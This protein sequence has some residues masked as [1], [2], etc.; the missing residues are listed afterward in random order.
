M[1]AAIAKVLAAIWNSLD[2]EKRAGLISGIAILVVC[3]ICLLLLPFYLMSHPIEAMGLAESDADYAIIQQFRETNTWYMP[4]S[5]AADTSIV[6]DS[7]I[8]ISGDLRDNQIPL[9]LQGDK[10]WGHHPY[11]DHGTL[12]TS[13]CGP[14]SMA[15]VVV[16]LTGNTDVN[17][18]VTADW[19]A[20]HGYRASA[21]TSWGFF[22][23]CACAYGVH[24]SQVSYNAKS[25]TETLRSGKV[26]I[27]SMK[28]GHF[29]KGGHFIVL[30]GITAEGKI[31][32]N[33]PASTSRSNQ[34][35]DVSII[36]NECK[37]AWAF[38]K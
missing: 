30:R 33:D 32:V 27:T 12:A 25:I 13:A 36:Q 6:G 11:G 5:E 10:R 15:M 24:C 9:F 31:L 18:K 14:T 17:P 2:E 4:D 3:V 29:T 7:G 1:E 8:N 19:S 21:G 34:T 28:P 20:A 16:G 38:W 23:A 37:S 35:W 22:S 26:M